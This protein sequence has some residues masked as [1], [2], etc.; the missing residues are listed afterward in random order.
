[1][2]TDLQPG[3]QRLLVDRL[4]RDRLVPV[5]GHLLFFGIMAWGVSGACPAS[6]IVVWG[7]AVVAVMAVRM[8]VWTR[9]RAWPPATGRVAVRVMMTALGLSWGFG[10][11]HTAWHVSPFT[12]AL[13]VMGLAGL[14]VGAVSTVVADRWA[15][16]FY[17]LTMLAPPAAG[18]VLS[19][20]LAPKDL[21]VILLLLVLFGT[22][23]MV[24]H[25]RAYHALVEGFAALERLRASERS[26][27]EAQRIAHV[28]SWDVDLASNMVTWSDESYRIWGREPGTPV[29]YR[30]FL[31]G[32]HPDDRARVEA[33]TGEAMA[34]GRDGEFE[35]RVVR[36]DGAIRHV[37]NR[38]AFSIDGGGRPARMAGVSLDITARKLAEEQRESLVRDLQTALAEVK[39]LRGLI[40]ICAHCR[41][42]LTDEGGWTQFEAYVRDNSEAEFTHGICPDCAARWAAES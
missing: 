38:I 28:G 33:V 19:G 35:C 23:M 37:V 18:I 24:E 7:G 26:L 27:V 4:L 13:I 10:T 41:R 8:I 12:F 21:A 31:A 11:A 17:L 6:H 9:A 1:M 20:L 15:F 29:G 22:F 34:T 16:R 5:L 42:V 25:R 32:V 39:T 36:P 2:R 3:I 14:L 40:R 30:E